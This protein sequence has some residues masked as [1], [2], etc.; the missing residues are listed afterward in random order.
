MKEIIKPIDNF[1]D[2]Q[3]SNFGYVKSIKSNTI[4]KGILDKRGYTCICLYKKG[5]RHFFRIHRLV[6]IAYIEN[7]L[8]KSQVNH[9][10]GNKQNNVSDNL[11]WATCQENIIHAN[12]N[13]LFD[14]KN[15]KISERMKIL[16]KGKSFNHKN[17]LDTTTGIFYDSL[18]QACIS[19]NL[20]YST[21]VKRTRKQ[22]NN[23]FLYI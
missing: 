17:V 1:E 3:I 6:A 2:Y 4:L 21:E 5:V 7:P 16:M 9:I 13:G 15:K 20:S 10:D 8:K 23:R 19:N 18:T 12:Q 11:E 22:K 14:I